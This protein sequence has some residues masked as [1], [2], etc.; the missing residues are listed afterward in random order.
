MS[1]FQHGEVYVT[2]D[3][4][5]TDLD[6]GHYERF[7]RTRLTGKNSITTGKIYESVIR[8]ERRGDYLGGTVQVIPHITD[9]IKR[10][11]DEATDGYRRRPGRD[12]RHRRRH[13]VAAVPGGDPPDP[14]RARPGQGAVHAPD[15]GAVHRGGR[16][17]QDQ[18]DPALGQGT[19]LD[20][21]PARRPAVP[22]R[23]AA[24][25]RRAPQDRAVHQRAGK[26]GHLRGRRGQHLQDPAV[27]A[28]AGARRDRGRA[29]AACGDMAKP[30]DLSEWEA[31]V[32]AASIR[33][34]RS[35]SPSSAST[36]TTRMP[37]SRWPKRCARRHRASAP[38]ST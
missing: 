30:A 36:S 8:K 25:R 16:R 10:C 4:A 7:V 38:G 3:G 24:A 18:A 34:T 2:D 17:A 15:P 33:S 14:H 6:L 28:R 5:E 29:P 31:V 20:R 26:G 19:A 37:T 11:I 1:P 27:A 32:D 23:A 12:R 22:Q 9:E 13:R 35:R 21:H